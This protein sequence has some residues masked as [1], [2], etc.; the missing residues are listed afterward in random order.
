[1]PAVH[2][3]FLHVSAYSLKRF[4]RSVF[5]RGCIAYF[6]LLAMISWK[7]G[8]ADFRGELRTEVCSLEFGGES[9]NLSGSRLVSGKYLNYPL[10][11]KW[12]SSGFAWTI[13]GIEFQTLHG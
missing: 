11:M 8:W 9:A 13:L 2:F 4:E 7:P 6:G 5:G 1:M 3:L 12:L 10:K